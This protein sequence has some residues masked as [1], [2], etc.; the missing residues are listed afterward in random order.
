M[1]LLHHHRA[2]VTL[3][4]WENESPPSQFLFKTY[5][6]I[7]NFNHDGRQLMLPIEDKKN[8][9]MGFAA[10][11]RDPILAATFSPSLVLAV[12]D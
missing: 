3:S 1:A 10:S 5:V 4:V 11:S 7:R 8:E 6:V 12:M 2:L 9:S